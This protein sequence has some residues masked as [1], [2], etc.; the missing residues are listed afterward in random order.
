MKSTIILWNDS[1]IFPEQNWCKFNNMKVIVFIFF[2]KC[3]PIWFI[4]DNELILSNHCKSDVNFKYLTVA[5]YAPVICNLLSSPAV[6]GKCWACD[7]MQ[8]YPPGIYFYKEQG[9]NS[10]QVPAVQGVLQGCDG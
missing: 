1:Y 2:F 8:I 9:Y 7:I 3:L 4:S 6:L 10:Q 5:L